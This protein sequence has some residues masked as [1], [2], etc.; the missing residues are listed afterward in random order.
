MLV[1]LFTDKDFLSLSLKVKVVVVAYT[2]AVFFLTA[3][4]IRLA[5][6]RKTEAFEKFLNE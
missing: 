6:G 2:S 5:Y 1:M 3:P 4:Y